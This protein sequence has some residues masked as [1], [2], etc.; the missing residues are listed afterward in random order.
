MDFPERLEDS[1][2]SEMGL[3][4]A[5]VI[6]LLSPRVRCGLRRG[7]ILGVTSLLV[8]GDSVVALARRLIAAAETS[9]SV[10]RQQLVDEA[11]VE[12]AKRVRIHAAARE[13]EKP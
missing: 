5:V 6:V 2:E 3:A 9:D 11:R 1:L 4:A 13:Y 7:L 8:A 10:F 12:Q